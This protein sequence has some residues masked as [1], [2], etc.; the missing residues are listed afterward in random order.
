VIFVDGPDHDNESQRRD[1]ELKR[2]R[3][4]LMGYTVFTIHYQDDL[5]AKIKDLLGLLL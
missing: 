2:E 5:E 4:D 1:D 3:L